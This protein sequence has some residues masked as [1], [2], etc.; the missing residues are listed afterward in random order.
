M[1]LLFS[2][3][4]NDSQRKDALKMGVEAFRALP[5]DLQAIWSN[6]GPR[7]ESI[8]PTGESI[9]AWLREEAT[10]GDYVLVQGE[11]G[12]AYATIRRAFAL[13]LIP[14]YATTKRESVDQPQEDGSVKRVLTFKHVRFRKY[15]E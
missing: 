14:V 10:P 5:S 2:H 6:V 3:Q 4:L 1:F 8:L 7:S 11:F 15:E 12:L 13:N 9:W